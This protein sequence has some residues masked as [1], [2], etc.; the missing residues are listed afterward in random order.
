METSTT[1][2]KDKSNWQAQF[3][4]YLAL[5]SAGF[6]FYQWWNSEEATKINA[7]VDISRKFFEDKNFE[8]Y[9]NTIGKI[10]EKF[11][12][13]PLKGFETDIDSK[14]NLIKY[15]YHMDYIA[16]LSN[17]KLIEPRYMSDLLK[18]NIFLSYFV[19]DRFKDSI[20]KDVSIK[21][22]KTFIDK[23]PKLK[24]DT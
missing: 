1:E 5:I 21:D 15:F 8:T 10:G 20:F 14:R 11:A 4:F 12:D 9:M 7:T 18:C 19:Y 24:C 17:R 23:T 6:S 2:A 3:A 22:T 16:S 13:N